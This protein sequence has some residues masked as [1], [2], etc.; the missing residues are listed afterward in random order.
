MS[1]SAVVLLLSLAAA[2]SAGA[3]ADTVTTGAGVDYDDVTV[4]GLDGD[5]LTFRST[6]GRTTSRPLSEVRR[7]TLDGQR[8]FNDAE[9]AF[10]TGSPA[11]AVDGY[12]RTV[13][14]GNADWL[15]NFAARRLLTAARAAG[16]FPAAAVAYATLAVRA[17]ADAVL[18][19]PELPDSAG[20]DA[21]RV[22]DQVI[23]DALARRPADE[24]RRA[25][26]S[27]RLDL[28]RALGDAAAVSAT[29]DELSALAGGMAADTPAARRQLADLRLGQAR[30]ALDR[31]GYQE[32]FTTIDDHA[33]L[34]ADPRQAAEALYIRG[35][36]AEAMAGGDR[37]KLLDAALDYLRVV[38][39]Y[40]SLPDAPRVAA[41]LMRAAA[42]H[43]TLGEADA[44]RQLYQA[45]A[46]EFPD[47]PEAADAKAR[48][49]FLAG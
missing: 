21:L 36:A 20:P 18:L 13:R 9:D 14:G 42:I 25:L 26:L 31:E 22:A 24:A 10:A 5:Q 12:L 37:Q 38:A 17:P 15:Q 8:A 3:S 19:K 43:E 34:F 48:A 41:S 23:D 35:R 2:V 45:V 28:R 44:A 6:T 1:R 32:A 46:A 30:L 47:A 11:D 29:L 40:K 7:L 16:D 49:A 4:T 27:F 39:H 33:D